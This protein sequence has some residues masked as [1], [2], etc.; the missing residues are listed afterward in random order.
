MGDGV[1]AGRIYLTVTGTSA[2][3][4]D[5][6]EAGRGNRVGGLITPFRPMTMESAAGKNPITH[7]GKLYNVLAGLIARDLV[8]E[9]SA[10]RTADVFL[11]S[12]IGHPVSNPH[13]AH[14]RL[15]LEEGADLE[16]V[17]EEIEERFRRRLERAPGLWR[18]L[19]D[20]KHGIYL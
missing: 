3:S 12:R 6:G 15:G 19:I 18:E 2:E 20:R 16:D 4:G 14:A 9:V 1:L 10:V 17:R 13:L 5:D 11:V 8:G 7:V